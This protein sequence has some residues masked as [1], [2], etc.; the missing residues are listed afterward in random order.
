MFARD[1]HSSL[2]RKSVYFSHKKFY[3]TAPRLKDIFGV[4]AIE[5]HPLDAYAGKLK[6]PQMSN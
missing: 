3:S 1:K 4:P 2:L 6:L 5:Q